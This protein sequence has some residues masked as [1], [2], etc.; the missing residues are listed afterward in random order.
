MPRTAKG[1]RLYLRRGRT[2]S[3]TGRSLPDVY[4]IRDGQA[5]VSTGCGPSRLSEAERALADYIAA[6]W[7]APA[8]PSERRGDPTQVLVAEVLALY[9]QE[10]APTLG[11]DPK[12]TAG[13]IKALAAWWNDKT[14][15][16]VKRSSCNAYVEHRTAQPIA[17]AKDA[18]TARRVSAQTARRELELLSAAIGY[19]HGEDKLSVR[20]E[21]TLPAK[22]ESPRDA[23]TRAQAAALLKASL[24][25]RKRPDGSWER[26]GDKA[27]SRKAGTPYVR[28]RRSQEANRA[29]LRR[30]ILIALYTGTRHSVITRLLWAEAAQQAWVDLDAGMIYRRGVREREHRTKRRPVVKLPPRL[31]AHMRRWRRLDAARDA[32]RKARGLY[33]LN[34]VLHHGGYP[35]AGKIRTGFEGCVRDAGL[36]AEITPHWL[37]HTAAT[38]LMEAGVDLWT[39]GGYLGMSP[40]TLE[41]HYGHHRPDYQAEASTAIGRRR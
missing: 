18:A 29:H 16:Q 3:R 34:T 40:T 22:P 41:K 12:S 33:P 4:F 15:A 37:R 9:G 28:P 10:K 2:D 21:I 14:L 11:G 31:L 32:D 24:G 36:P 8:S 7:A 13:F 25:Y 30:F 5:Q 6:K 23:L 26:L 38:W 20:P 35:L 1:P 39:A 17:S 27:R 19:W